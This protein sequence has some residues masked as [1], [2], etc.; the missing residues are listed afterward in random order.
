MSTSHQ[1]TDLYTTNFN[2][3]FEAAS[4]EYKTLT[5]QGLETHPFAA[6]LEDYVSPNSVLNVFRKQARAFD[7]FRKG[8]DKLMALLTP[9]VYILSSVSET[10]RRGGGLVSIQFSTIYRSYNVHFLSPS[11][12]QRYSLLLSVSFS[13]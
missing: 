13:G 6:A 2:A 10:L 11:L 7:I 9:I 8:D 1:T 4:N 3:I 5:G 12:P